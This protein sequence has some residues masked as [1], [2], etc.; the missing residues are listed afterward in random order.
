MKHVLTPVVLIGV[1]LCSLGCASVERPDSESALPVNRDNE[2][3]VCNSVSVALT[4]LETTLAAYTDEEIDKESFDIVATGIAD[5]FGLL[6]TMHA[7]REMTSAAEELGS[8]IAG[9]TSASGVPPTGDTSDLGRLRTSLA[10]LCDEAGTPL[11]V[12]H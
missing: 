5:S 10:L 4:I 3:S 12:Y 2:S 7:S 11:S 9:L 8:A 1:L 6:R